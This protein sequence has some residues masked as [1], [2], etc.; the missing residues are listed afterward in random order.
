MQ[1][2]ELLHVG[3]LSALLLGILGGCFVK[4]RGWRDWG[5]V[6]SLG[7]LLAFVAE[8]YIGLLVRGPQGWPWDAHP[9]SYSPSLWT[10]ASAGR[11]WAETALLIGSQGL[12]LG[13]LVLLGLRWTAVQPESVRMGESG[14]GRGQ[15]PVPC[16]GL[17]LLSGG[18]IIA[19]PTWPTIGAGLTLLAILVFTRVFTRR[20]DP[21]FS[22]VP[23]PWPG[24]ESREAK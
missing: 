10:N 12:A 21:P 19:W 7:L 13:G 24:V 9:L 15:S 17:L 20:G 8:A 16:C 3:F 2:P 14:E 6:A 22:E 1:A 5:A 4:T 18:I 23:A 11:R